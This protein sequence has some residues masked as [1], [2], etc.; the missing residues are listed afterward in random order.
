VSVI[1]LAD[2]QGKGGF[3][4]KDT[5]AG[6]YGS[7]FTGDSFA[8]RLGVHLRGIVQNVPSIHIGYLAA[9]FAAAG[10]KIIHTRDDRPVEGDLAL[11][12]TSLV[13]HKHE[14]EW[15]RAAR[16]RGIKVGFFGQ[17]ATHL[18][19]LFNGAGD[20]I[21]SGEPEAAALKIAA[22]EDPS[23]LILSP[24]ID[25]L[26]SLPFPRWDQI[27]MRRF[28][29]ISRDHFGL[30]RALPMLTSRSCPEHC[31]YCP[32]RIT[33]NFRARSVNNVISEMQE[34]CKLYRRPHI[35]IR[36]PL[37]TLDRERCFRIAEQISTRG[38]DL[39]YECETR[40]DDLDED[41]IRAM[42]A[43]GLREISFGV[44]SP[45]PLVLKKVARRFIPHEHMRKMINLCWELGITTIAFYVIGFLQDSEES[46]EELVRF[47]MD[48]DS[49]F[50]NFKILT[51]Y[52]GTPQ[53]K[54]LKPLIW[55]TDWEKFDG[56]TLNFRHPVLTPK[57]ARL[58][59]G[60]AY[61][62]YFFRP[63]QLCNFFGRHGY[64]HHPLL[65]RA[66]EWAWR[67][68]THR[69]RSWRMEPASRPPTTTEAAKV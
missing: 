53:F 55:E 17:P 48:L 51:P 68:Q 61:A 8:T 29:H 12:L 11:V 66:D 14:C 41:L 59:L 27:K 35:V 28:A 24:A 3:V 26:D 9:I 47:S 40:M 20:F 45:D 1:I 43:S 25:D 18:P 5:V 69:D 50:A 4:N 21:I 60:M 42:H 58:M 31:T 34:L 54:Q 36:D 38:L 22:G 30:V 6:G 13:D 56:Y 2:L 46:I 33:A 62:R 16:T 15:A 49:T 10:H 32:H 67:K 63:S 7:R 19:E 52:P 57:R 65:K 64:A 39:T 37:Y 44:E 23:G